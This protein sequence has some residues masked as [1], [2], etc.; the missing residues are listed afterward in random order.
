MARDA[1]LALFSAMVF[2]FFAVSGSQ[3]WNASETFDDET[4]RRY[5]RVRGLSIVIQGVVRV[6]TVV[7]AAAMFKAFVP[8]VVEPSIKAGF[9][10]FAIVGGLVA[11]ELVA[12]LPL[13]LGS[14]LPPVSAATATDSILPLWRLFFYPAF[15]GVLGYLVMKFRGWWAAALLTALI[16][17]TNGIGVAGLVSALLEWLK[18]DGEFKKAPTKVANDTERLLDFDRSNLRV[19]GTQPGVNAFADPFGRVTLWQGTLK[20]LSHRG[21]M[22]VVGHEVGHI[23]IAHISKR[24]WTTVLFSAVS[25]STVVVALRF[26][27]PAARLMGLP[28]NRV[29]KTV[30]GFIMFMTVEPMMRLLVSALLSGVSVK[31]EYEADAYSA[32]R[33]GPGPISEGLGKM[34]DLYGLSNKEPLA[35]SLPSH[36]P[37]RDRLKALA[38]YRGKYPDKL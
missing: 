35:I 37:I 25:I 32:T 16:A 6:L 10:I 14:G 21:V 13:A 7:F 29:A 5:Y 38:K 20:K 30:G 19:D 1:G 18:D 36:P 24:L 11:V 31:H 2:S 17:L 27:T 15:M 9:V 33:L 28:N 22:G 23:R 3:V 4:A 8:R 26:G 34:G 12:K